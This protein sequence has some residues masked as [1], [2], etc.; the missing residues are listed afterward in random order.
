MILKLG[1]SPCPN[2]TFIFE[3]LIA[4][5]TGLDVPSFNVHMADVEELNNMASAGQFDVCKLSYHA[6]STLLDQYQMLNSG[7]ALGFGVGP[8]LISK[9]KYTPDEVQNL[10][11]A[12]PGEA[13]TAHLLLKYA[14]PDIR[15]KR[16]AL[17]SEIENMV[18]S[19]EVNAGVIIHENRFTYERKGLYKI[20]DLGQ[21]WEDTTGCAIPLGGIAIKRDL[22][23]YVKTLVQQHLRKSI[24]MAF[25]RERKITDFISAHAQEMDNEVMEKHINL[26]V[27][28]YSLA[29]GLEGKHAVDT[30]LKKCEEINGNFVLR[31]DWLY[32]QLTH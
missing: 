13:T 8:L 14:F 27:N 15:E 11:I 19:E 22:D 12:I 23:S 31:Q 2:D 16:V 4:G 30:F 20:M 7:S 10:R 28:E 26:Y 6:F 17:F 18:L 21:Y 3:N 5:N 25:K 1:F 24:E 29:L 32:Q 9:K